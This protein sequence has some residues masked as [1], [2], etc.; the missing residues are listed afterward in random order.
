MK[1]SINEIKKLFD[2][3][4]INK[5]IILSD[6]SLFSRDTL[7]MLRDIIKGKRPNDFELSKEQE[8]MLIEAFK[9]SDFIFDDDT[10]R[11]II[12]D[13]ECVNIVIERDI[14]SVNYI[15]DFIP[16]LETKVINLAI[17]N[18]YIL[19]IDSPLILRSNYTIALNSIRQNPRTADYVAW[20]SIPKEVYDALISKVIESGYVLSQNSAAIL[21]DNLD[22]VLHSIAKDIKTLRYASNAARN[23]IKVFKY[24]LLN[25]YEFSDNSLEIQ[26]LVNYADKDIMVYVFNH[27][28]RNKI[29][30]FDSFF[31]NYPDKIAEYIDRFGSLFSDAIKMV[32]TISSF[33]SIFQFSA[34]TEWEDYKNDNLNDYANIFGKICAELQANNSFDDAFDNL[35]FLYNMEDVLGDKY[36]L[37]L[38]AMKEYHDIIHSNWQL[39]NL[40]NARNQIA[41][42][43]ALYISMS[44]ENYKKELL[45]EYQK[46]LTDY[47][48]PRKDHP[49]VYKKIMSFK[50]KE[51]IK[52]LY[53]KEDSNFYFL[54]NDIVKKYSKVIDEDILWEM[55]DN[56]ITKDYSKLDSFMQVPLGFSSY[57]RYKEASKLVN[58]LNSNYIKY[59]DSDLLRYLDIIKYDNKKGKYCYVGPTFS[60]EDIGEYNRYLKKQ[61]VFEDIKQIH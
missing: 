56:F 33:N 35:N 53:N 55:I 34:D 26:P 25:G 52:N 51:T 58:R 7:I 3:I 27:F 43:S 36:N 48:I 31:E 21:R 46:I 45:E 20:G 41:S 17:D 5:N 6:D 4:L 37:L 39:Y 60:I 42:L 28:I 11:F 2:F 54:L 44:K 38:Q 47:F 22:I 14:N 18:N 10:P 8:E 23:N 59:T 57:K 16:E 13:Y 29:A 19:Q 9:S 15:I 32:P 12:S 50:R 40:D 61:K 1:L 49:I 24:L 30:D